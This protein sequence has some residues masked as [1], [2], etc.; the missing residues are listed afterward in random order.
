MP[1]QPRKIRDRE[2]IADYFVSIRKAEE[3]IATGTI[4]HIAINRKASQ[5]P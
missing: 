3:I 1:K 4:G 2:S 5:N